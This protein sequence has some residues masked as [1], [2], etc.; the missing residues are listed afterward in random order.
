MTKKT[1]TASS[2]NLRD[3][4]LDLQSEMIASLTTN[5]KHILHPGTKGDSSELKWLKLFEDYLPERYKVAK[6][7]VL[8]CKGNLSEQIDIVIYDRQYSP[9]LFNKDGAKYV[10]A[11]SVYAVFEV[12]QDIDA[13]NVTYAAQKAA[14]VRKLHRTSAAIYHAGGKYGPKKPPSILAGILCLD[15]SW[16]ASFAK[17]VT[18][19]LKKL[20]KAGRLDLASTLKAGSFEATYSKTG[21]VKVDMSKKDNALIFF[22]LKL[23]ARLQRMGT[24]AALDFDDYS[25]VL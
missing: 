20:D 24:V 18:D 5:R 16:K 11:E 14:S 1:N 21:K 4:F 12:K 15:C 8:D 10:P 13:P 22:F 2:V 23:L 19:A 6:A 17:S 3:L 25:R 7:F 9:F